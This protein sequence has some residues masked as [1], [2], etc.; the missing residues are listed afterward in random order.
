MFGLFGALIYFG[1]RR[2]GT[3]GSAIFRQMVF[4]ALFALV[5]GFTNPMTDNWA[6]VGGLLGGL[7]L[8]AALGYQE[9]EKQKLAHHL[10]ALALLALVVVCF[11]M[12][13][14]KFFSGA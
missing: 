3:F 1:W 13:V 14:V 6:H 12:M 10:G 8:G 9:R 11:V 4:W 7:A 2:G 5:L